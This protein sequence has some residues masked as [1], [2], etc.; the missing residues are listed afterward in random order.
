M[1]LAATAI[2]EDPLVL[3]LIGLGLL[4]LFFWYFATEIERRKR[5]IGTVLLF[6]ICV[7]CLLAIFPPQERLKGGLDLVGGS[8]F[9]LR[10]Q[11]REGVNG[12]LLPVTTTQVDQA[13]AVIQRRLDG[14]GTA[15][16][17]IIRQGD[18]QILVQMPGVENA[19]EVRT[20]LEQVAKLEL[21]EVSPRSDERGPDGRTL[22]ERVFF[23]DDRVPGYRAYLY[24]PRTDDGTEIKG[25]ILLNR[26]MALG[27]SDVGNANPSQ[28][29]SDAVDIVLN[30]AGT[31][32]MIALTQNMTPRQD[33]IAIVLDGEVLSA[34]VV[35][36][37]PLGKRFQIEGLRDPGEPQALS[38]ALMNP[39]ENPL[40][41]EGSNT[42]TAS[43][44][45]AIVSQ[46]VW[47]AILGLSITFVFVLVYY[48]TAGIVALFGLLVNGIILFG[49]MAMFGFTFTLPGIAGIILTIGMAVDANV[50]IYERLREE[51]ENG[52][53]LK[54]AIAASY[55]KAFSA[56]FDANATSLISAIV[57]LWIGS[58]TLKGFAVTLTVGLLASM[59]SAILVTRVLFRWGVDTGVLRRLSFLNLIRSTN[60]DFLGKRRIALV[61]TLILIAASLAG[62]ATHRTDALGVD[63]TG[64]TLLGFQI[65]ERDVEIE[66]VQ[67]ALRELD[68]TRAA[69]AQQADNILTGTNISIRGDTADAGQIIAKLRESIP[70]LAETNPD[71]SY[72]INPDRAEVSAVIGAAFLREALI[73]LGLGLIAILIYITVR[74]EFSFALGAFVAL[75]HDVFIAVG[76]IVLFGGELSQIHVG[77]I[78]AIAGYSINDT[79][80]VFDRIRE[81][82]LMR[83]GSIKDI[84]NL[85][86]NA[87]LS[88]TILTSAT[89]IVTVSILSIFGGDALREFSIMILAGL[90]VGTYSSIFVASPVVLWWSRRKGGNLRNDVLASSVRAEVV[91]AVE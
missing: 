47:A 50:L 62:F 25:Y 87:T 44:G 22:A 82:L 68:L 38:R 74:F 33:R 39:L 30:N 70:V 78:L 16:S 91:P 13:I 31:E 19:D 49:V 55:D 67:R 66:S 76:L 59:F 26:R 21:R 27:G 12:E 9:T 14:M 53:S 54:N 83:S 29:Q 86:I 43:Y 52:K 46:G 36:Q 17:M 64:G 1:F 11:P 56:I 75:I 18:D 89:T 77:A 3:F 72:R 8:E 90:L 37:V 85:A 61:F 32:K 15:N 20:T 2:Y 5:N 58:G 4:I 41:V 73:A 7:L 10:V 63:F 6:G 69:Y 34:P 81:N 65:G 51:M 35:N 57:L 24:S 40:V 42:V 45:A 23:N 48:R 60:Y 88:R 71:G 28:M 80:V 84:M 79:I